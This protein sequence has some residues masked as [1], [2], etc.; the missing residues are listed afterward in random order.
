MYVLKKARIGELGLC[1]RPA[2]AIGSAAIASDDRCSPQAGQCLARLRRFSAAAASKTCSLAPLRPR[3]RSFSSPV[4]CFMWAKRASTLRRARDATAKAGVEESE[5]TRS[6]T[7][8]SGWRS[9]LRALAFVHCGFRAQAEQSRADARYRAPWPVT[10]SPRRVSSWPAG[11]MNRSRSGSKVNWS[12]PIQPTHHHDSPSAA[13]R[14]NQSR[15]GGS[16]AVFQR[17]YRCFPTLSTAPLRAVTSSGVAGF[18]SAT[19]LLHAQ[20]WRS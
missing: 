14:V 17:T 9:S 16:T 1:A 7:S 6:R 10:S 4:T 3:S 5:R 2:A 13:R 20:Q 8:S 19:A 11:Q 18:I 15:T 12:R